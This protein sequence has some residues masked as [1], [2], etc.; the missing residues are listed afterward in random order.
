MDVAVPSLDA[1]LPDVLAEGA[2]IAAAHGLQ[3]AVGAADELDQVTRL[4]HG[5]GR[6]PHTSPDAAE[7]SRPALLRTLADQRLAVIE[8][9]RAAVEQASHRRPVFIILMTCNGPSWPR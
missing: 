2:Q 3:A 1:W 5:C 6:C 9:I 8:C 4:R 7:R